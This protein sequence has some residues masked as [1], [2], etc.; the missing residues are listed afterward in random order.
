MYNSWPRFKHQKYY[1][2]YKIVI[3]CRLDRAREDRRYSW[4]CEKVKELTDMDSRL[5]ELED[6]RSTKTVVSLTA[7]I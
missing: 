3:S 4:S 7:G 5:L 6:N 1:K 2:I